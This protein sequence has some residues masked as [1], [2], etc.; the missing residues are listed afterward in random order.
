M[1]AL[2]GEGQEVFMTAIFTFHTG[3]AVVQIAAI[4]IAVNDLLQIGPPESVLPGE[5]LV[6]N[7][8]KGFKIVLYT[9][10]VI[11]RLRISWAINGGRKGHDFSPLRISCRHNVE[12]SF[13]LSREDLQGGSLITHRSLVSMQ[14]Y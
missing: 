3:K 2:A 7:P 10:V 14:I 6:I 8:D 12:R 4:E 11:R 13:Y 1:T 5:M 9:A